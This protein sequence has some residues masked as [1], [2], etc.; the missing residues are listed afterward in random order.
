MYIKSS[1]AQSI[2]IPHP[3]KAFISFVS[4]SRYVA[5][6]SIYFLAI[7][8]LALKLLLLLASTASSKT[9]GQQ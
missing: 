1:S 4:F 9:P 7:A 3:A 5:P 8:S 6:W 2:N